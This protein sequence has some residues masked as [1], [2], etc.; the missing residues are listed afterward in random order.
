MKTTIITIKGTHC[1]SCKALIE[2]V[3]SEIKGVKSC[4][5]NFQTGETVVEHDETLDWQLF[6][7]EI[8]GLG[9]YKLINV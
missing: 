9:Q 5:V 8:E 3:C 1:S 2:D 7:K 6:K 4:T